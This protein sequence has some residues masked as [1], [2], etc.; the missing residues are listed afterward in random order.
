MRRSETV[1]CERTWSTHARLRKGLSI[2]PKGFLQDELV[3]RQLGYCLLQPIILTLELFQAPGL[4][5]L[6]AAIFTPPLV[7]SLL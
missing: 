2:F 6:Q 3:Q 4:V 1:S 5:D 7:K